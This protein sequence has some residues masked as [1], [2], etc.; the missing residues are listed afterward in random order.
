MFW[1]SGSALNPL[2]RLPVVVVDQVDDVRQRQPVGP[3]RGGAQAEIRGT[4]VTRD[5]RRQVTQVLGEHRRVA[6][7][8][9]HELVVPA[10][11]VGHDGLLAAINATSFVLAA[12]IAARA[13]LM[14]YESC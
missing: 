2:V 14:Q 4:A 13:P 8:D 5:D 1:K 3:D 9:E 10:A 7:P 11:G 12:T 6:D